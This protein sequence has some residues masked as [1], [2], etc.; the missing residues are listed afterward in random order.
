MLHWNSL[1]PRRVHLVLPALLKRAGRLD[2]VY[3]G[4][5]WYLGDSCLGMDVILGTAFC[6]EWNLSLRKDVCLGVSFG[7][8]SWAQSLQEE[9]VGCE[10][11]T[12]CHDDSDEDRIL[13]FWIFTN[14]SSSSL[15]SPSSS[16]RVLGAVGA[17]ESLQC[18]LWRRTQGACPPVPVAAGR[19]GSTVPGHGHGAVPLLPGGL[20]GLVSWSLLSLHMD[21]VFP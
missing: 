10:P 12:E 16:C 7:M 15:L 13:T 9:D 5:R 21:E 18:E 14:K 6:L 3:L 1:H 11:G 4:N 8:L 2:R 17:L 20:H 19:S